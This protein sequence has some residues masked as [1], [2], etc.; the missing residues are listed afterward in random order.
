MKILQVITSLQTGGA[1]MLVCQ[2]TLRLRELGHQVDVC[3]FNG[4]ETQLLG[5][6]REHRDVKVYI[7]GH[8]YYNPWYIVR[9]A[10]I[11]KDYDV[12]HTHNSSPQLFVAIANL[13][14]HKKLVTTEH[15][16]NNRKREHPMFSFVDRWM[17]RQYN[18]VVCISGIAET[19]L[20]DYLE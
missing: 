17:Y 8:S 6:L 9:L 1:E 13:F 19:K 3:V 12:I 2:M 16:T 5:Q 14:C 15:S 4:V 7:L 20:R 18:A 11:M 10:R